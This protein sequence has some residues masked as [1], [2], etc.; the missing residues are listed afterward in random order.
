MTKSYMI[1]QKIS[2]DDFREVKEAFEDPAQYLSTEQ[3]VV[4]G[5]FPFKT[6]KHIQNKIN[7]KDIL[8]SYPTLINNNPSIP[9][10]ESTTTNQ[11]PLTS[12]S[13]SKRDPVIIP[14]VKENKSL[15]IHYQIENEEILLKRYTKSKELEAESH[16]KGFDKLISS[17][18]NEVVKHHYLEQDKLLKKTRASRVQ[19]AKVSKNLSKSVHKKEED[20]LMNRIDEH[21]IRTQML[22]LIDNDKPISEKYGNNYWMFSLRRP[23]YLD[24]I[25]VNYINVGSV[26]REIW[27]PF[28]EFPHRPVEIIQNSEN[29]KTKKYSKW[30]DCTYY[31]NE[32]KQLN[33]NLPNMDGINELKVEGKKLVEEEYKFLKD[34]NRKSKEGLKMILYNDP[35]ERKEKYINNAVYKESYPVSKAY[36][37]HCKLK[38]NKK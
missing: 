1:N 38:S 12:K 13:K 17:N 26:E 29:K 22:A 20:L 34:D 24:E 18:A 10:K 9:T 27:K 33:V 25:R 19:S 7:E 31:R 30:V 3:K 14:K 23:K 8:Q 28:L 21:R 16:Q 6:K 2:K 32:M 5:L 36:I 15:A 35:Y 4:V 37:C 11:R